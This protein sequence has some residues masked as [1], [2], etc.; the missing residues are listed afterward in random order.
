MGEDAIVIRDFVPGDET[1]FRDINLEWIERYFVVETKDR[2]T[3]EQARA[4]IIDP[5][6]AIL[7]AMDGAAPVGCVALIVMDGAT[8]ELAK[9][10]VRPVAQGKGVGRKLVAGAL[11]KARAMGARRIYLETNSV[12]GPALRLYADA[13]FVPARDAPPSPYARAD[14]Q[15]ELLL[16]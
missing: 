10:G 15:L 3:L 4:K 5:G 1:A 6:G 9:M 8:V 13:G 16:S 7:M 11:A 14:V 2:E 12:L